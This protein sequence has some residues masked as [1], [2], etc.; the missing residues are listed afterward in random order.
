MSKEQVIH[1]KDFM[2]SSSFAVPKESL[3]PTAV[4]DD[5][6]EDTLSVTNVNMSD[7][8]PVTFMDVPPVVITEIKDVQGRLSDIVESI[9]AETGL[10]VVPLEMAKIASEVSRLQ[11]HE[12]F[13]CGNHRFAMSSKIRQSVVDRYIDRITRTLSS[14][15]PFIENLTK[16]VTYKGEDFKTYTLSRQEWT[17][18]MS[19]FREYRQSLVR[20]NGSDIVLEISTEHA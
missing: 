10:S 12:I 16:I 3:V 15:L 6:V 7:E 9:E 20:T 14:G 8:I 13:E 1:M 4:E 11:R 19:A 5:F 17:Y 18:I 2:Q